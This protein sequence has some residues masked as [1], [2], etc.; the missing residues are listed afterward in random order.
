M[1][2]VLIARNANADGSSDDAVCVFPTEIGWMGIVGRVNTVRSVYVGHAS[3]SSVKQAI[4]QSLLQNDSKQEPVEFDWSPD[5]RTALQ[6]YAS[7]ERVTFDHFDLFLPNQTP[8]RDRVIAA[9]RRIQ[10][11][12]T[13]TYGELARRVGN[14]GAA[15]AVGTAM[16]TNRF[17]ILIPC[18]RVVAAGGKLGGYTCPIGTDLKVRLLAIEAEHR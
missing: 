6:A 17:P 12:H 16:S 5:L 9:T 8:F 3:K 4:R 14:P 13:A 11:G 7:G 10:Y 15:R 2:S 18:H 1:K